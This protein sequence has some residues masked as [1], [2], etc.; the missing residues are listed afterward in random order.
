MIHRDSAVWWLAL[1]AFTSLH[2]ESDL[3]AQQPT[4]VIRAARMLDVEKGAVV[5]PAVVVVTGDR[6]EIV[7][8]RMGR[9]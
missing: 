8:P 7:G 1:L 3:S 9:R 4:V 2:P 5:S 6:G